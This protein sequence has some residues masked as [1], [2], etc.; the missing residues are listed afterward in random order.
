[1]LLT[2]QL[3]ILFFDN[4][5]YRSPF[6]LSRHTY[7]TENS[8]CRRNVNFT[9]HTIC[10]EILFNIRACRH[11]DWR[12]RSICVALIG[13]DGV[14]MD[15]VE[16]FFVEVNNIANIMSIQPKVSGFLLTNCQ[17]NNTF[18]IPTIIVQ[19]IDDLA[20]EFVLICWIYNAFWVTTFEVDVNIDAAL[21]NCC[22]LTPVDLTQ[23]ITVFIFLHNSIAQL[24]H[25][26]NIHTKWVTNRNCW[27]FFFRADET[28]VGSNDDIP[29]FIEQVHET[30]EI[31]VGIYI[32]PFKNGLDIIFIV[33]F[34]M[35][36]ILSKFPENMS[37]SV[38]IVQVREHDIIIIFLD[39]RVHCACL[40]FGIRFPQWC[41]Y[42][43][44]GVWRITNDHANT[45]ELTNFILNLLKQGF[46]MEQRI[47]V[48]FHGIAIP[49]FNLRAVLR[50]FNKNCL[51][52]DI[53]FF[54]I[55]SNGIKDVIDNNTYL[56][57]YNNWFLSF[58]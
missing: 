33:F 35:W 58:L 53:Y 36:T 16:S 57:Q 43:I 25:N 14:T 27:L 31:S 11:K 30:T 51:A 10:Y 46:W 18:A 42:F 7:A 39:Q 26:L 8:N 5:I 4:L 40:P 19:I 12:Y 47:I 17:S 29:T 52:N 56:I 1:M 15:T 48:H 24:F 21:S 37:R 41:V 34:Y 13:R 9:D 28:M 54:T 44:C 38:N 32:E 3:S 50:K 55:F 2:I 23:V 49:N 22:S 45:S 20:F 6:T